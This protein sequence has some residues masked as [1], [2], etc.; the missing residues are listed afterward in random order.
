LL[1]FN[2]E[3]FV[4]QWAMKN[5]QTK[6]DRTIVLHECEAWSATLKEVNRLTVKVLENRVLCR[7]GP[8]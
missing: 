1:S 6:I 2:A 8:F 5:V 7:E 4:F 3:S